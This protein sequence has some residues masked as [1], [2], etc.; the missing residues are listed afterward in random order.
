MQEPWTGLKKYPVLFLTTVLSE[1]VSF[2]FD[3]LRFN[4][5]NSFFFL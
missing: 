3:T 5:S 4:V 2:I 1:T